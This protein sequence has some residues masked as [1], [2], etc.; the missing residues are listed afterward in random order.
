[1]VGLD[2][3]HD[4]QSVLGQLVDGHSLSRHEA[5]AA[6]EEIVGGEATDAQ[7]A[8]LLVGLRAKG[9]TAAEIAGM[10]DAMLCAAVTFDYPEPLLDTCGT[11]GDRHGT[12]N[13]STCAAFVCA[14]AGVKVAK[15]GNRAASSQCGSADVLEALGVEIELGPD[16]AT[17]CL[18]EAGIAFLFA[19]R[20]HPAMRHAAGVRA[21]LGIR[22]VMNFLGPLSNPARAQYQAMGVSSPEMAP[23]LADALGQLGVERALVFS[24]AD[25]LD[26]LSIAGE[27]AIIDIS[28]NG[29][30][31][32]SVSP[33]NV[34][35]KQ[36]NLADVKGGDAKTNA[37]LLKSVLDDVQG[38]PLEMAVLNAAAGIVASG[39]ADD[40]RDGVSLARESISS[41]RAKA[42]AERLVRVSHEAKEDERDI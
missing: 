17:R 31:S 39:L 29:Q 35:V 19:R 5:K 14:G 1:M 10:V 40:L 18:D 33:A 41:G 27:T 11:G 42:A 7:I 38:P 32:F 3:T 8:A 30:R 12:F 34:G 6:M 24:A 20:Y 2:A 36:G 9:E 16:E 4:W 22:T 21:E 13:V 26:E 37:D 23:I 25:G 15:H 28:A